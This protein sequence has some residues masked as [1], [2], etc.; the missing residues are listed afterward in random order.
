MAKGNLFQGMARG[1]VGDVVFYRMNGIQMSRVRNR[2]PKNPRSNEQ[3]YQR[4]VI[5]SVMKNYSQGKEIYDHS[6]QGYTRGEG[7]MR[8]F[9]SVNA[10]ILR[11]EL[12]T[13]IQTNAGVGSVGRFTWPKS[14]FA[15]PMIGMQVSEGTLT[16]QMFRRIDSQG[17]NNVFAFAPSLEN[18][19]V[20]DYFTR[21]GTVP[22]DIYT[23][24]FHVVD[25]DNLVYANTL[26]ESD[27][28]EGYASAFYWYRLTLKEITNPT[29]KVASQ[30]ISRLFMIESSPGIDLNS[31]I[32]S[33]GTDDDSTYLNFRFG[34][35][36]L[37]AIGVAACIRSRLDMD[38]RSTEY[39]EEY[40]DNLYGITSQY[41]LQVWQDWVEKI[42]VSELI[43]EG[44]DGVTSSSGLV[45][46]SLEAGEILAE[47]TKLANIPTNEGGRKTARHKGSMPNTEG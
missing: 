6:F 44:G 47:E 2:D 21:M 13:D 17:P 12:L 26:T 11:R 42:G 38:V 5:S 24:V 46:H 20:A 39:T 9:N 31:G 15:V 8:R 19:T 28:A 3:L 45:N 14:N 33:I 34:P 30:L 29:E 7:C 37:D 35:N 40:G 10:N 43:L 32:V 16:N 18:E 1:K 22:G 27:Y 41:V 36:R 4:A 25:K 23:F